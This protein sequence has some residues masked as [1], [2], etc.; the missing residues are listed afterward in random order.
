MLLSEIPSSF[1]SHVSF[2]G[3]TPI[4]KAF[5]LSYIVKIVLAIRAWFASCLVLGLSAGNPS[6]VHMEFTQVFIYILSSFGT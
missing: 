3:A 1:F 6:L 2:W 5:L 4:F